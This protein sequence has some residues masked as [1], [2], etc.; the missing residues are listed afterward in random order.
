MTLKDSYLLGLDPSDPESTFAF[1]ALNFV[2]GK[3]VIDWGSGGNRSYIMQH[4][5]ALSPANWQDYGDPIPLNG[6]GNGRTSEETEMD[7]PAAE[8]GFFRMRLWP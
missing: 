3:M 6:N 5:P 4:T 1:D 8:G 7:M 2:N